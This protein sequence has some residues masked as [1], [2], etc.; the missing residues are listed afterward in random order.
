MNSN[1]PGQLYNKNVRAL[2]ARAHIILGEFTAKILMIY[3]D[4]KI[5]WSA[6]RTLLIILIHTYIFTYIWDKTFNM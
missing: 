4:H 5:T 6:A 2:H 3:I 1:R